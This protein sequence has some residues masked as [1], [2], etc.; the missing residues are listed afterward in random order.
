MEISNDELV[1]LI[2]IKI[3]NKPKGFKKPPAGHVLGLSW[4]GMS[5]FTFFLFGFT[6]FY[7]DLFFPAGTLVYVNAEWI[8]DAACFTNKK[9]LVSNII[10]HIYL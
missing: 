2:G 7:T 1:V 8:D 10:G 4:S 9:K 3:N 5:K 6:I